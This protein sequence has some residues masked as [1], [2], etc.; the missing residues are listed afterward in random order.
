MMCQTVREFFSCCQWPAAGDGCTRN[1]VYR[2]KG[3][4]W[5]RW[6]AAHAY[7]SLLL[8]NTGV[9]P[10]VAAATVV[11]LVYSCRAA[12]TVSN[13]SHYEFYPLT[14]FPWCIPGGF[15]LFPCYPPHTRATL[16]RA[17]EIPLSYAR[18][19]R[20]IHSDCGCYST[21]VKLSWCMA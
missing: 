14:C 7:V 17:P 15:S 5:L 13:G 9:R 16:C 1:S 8:S 2:A 19:G 21:V 11:T 20:C 6:P 3:L 18:Q 12:C 4:P 10:R